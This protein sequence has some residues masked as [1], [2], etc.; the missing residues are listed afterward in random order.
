MIMVVIMV[1]NVLALVASSRVAR[2]LE[3]IDKVQ[4][5]EGLRFWAALHVVSMQ[6]FGWMM[7]WSFPLSRVY[8]FVWTGIFAVISGLAMGGWAIRVGVARRILARE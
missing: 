3:R 4:L 6:L 8:E 7:I 5:A 1:L 2:Q